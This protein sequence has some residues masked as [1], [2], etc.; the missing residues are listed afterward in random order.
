M[1]AMKQWAFIEPA[2]RFGKAAALDQFQI[3]GR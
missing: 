3:G 1:K 2:R